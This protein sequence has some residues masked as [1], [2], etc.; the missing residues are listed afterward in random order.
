ADGRGVELLHVDAARVAREVTFA[1]PVRGARPLALGILLIIA[2]RLALAAATPLS[3]DE[4]YYW[5]W[6]KHLAAGYYDH[7]PLIAFVVRA[8]T[9]VFGDT[10]LGVRF[11]PWLLSVAATWA[12]WRAGAALLRSETDGLVAAL[13]FNLM[14]IIGVEALVAT[15]DAPEIAAASFLLLAL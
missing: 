10:S 13:L 7:P 11:V 6:S 4:A 9:I 14:P 15:P 1:S 2:L 3:Y 5:L 8:G 12:V